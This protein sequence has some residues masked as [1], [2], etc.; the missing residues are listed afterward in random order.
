MRYMKLIMVGVGLLLGTT[1][2]FSQINIDALA[3]Y[4]TPYSAVYPGYINVA[5]G[6]PSGITVGNQNDEIIS[7]TEIKFCPGFGCTSIA[8]NGYFKAI[9]GAPTL[10][11]VALE[12]GNTNAVGLYEKIEFGL[13]MPGFDA[14]IE[15]F[16]NACASQNTPCE[17][18]PGTTGYTNAFNAGTLLNPYDPEHISVEAY[19]FSPTTSQMNNAKKRFGFFYRTVNRVEQNG[20]YVDWSYEYPNAQYTSSVDLYEWRVRFAPDEIGEWKVVIRY[21]IGGVLQ[22]QFYWGSFTVV[23]SDNKGFVKVNPINNGYLQFQNGE[24]F[25]P[26]GDNYCWP[27]TNGTCEPEGCMSAN[28]VSEWDSR[29]LPTSFMEET[30]VLDRLSNYGNEVEGG[31][32]SRVWQSAGGFDFEWERLGNYNTRQI[33]MFEFDE[34]LKLAK[35][36]G[37]YLDVSSILSMIDNGDTHEKYSSAWLFNP[38]HDAPYDHGDPL[39]NIGAKYRG[40]EDLDQPMEFFTNPTAIKFYKNK[41]RYLFSRWGYA[42]NFAI[43]EFT[44]EVDGIQGADHT[45]YW[46]LY[47]GLI[48]TWCN[49][50]ASYIKNEL[51]AKQLITSSFGEGYCMGYRNSNHTVLWDMGNIDLVTS[52]DY[53]RSLDLLTYKNASTAHAIENSNKPCMIQ[54]ASV[55]GLNQIDPCSDRAWH[56]IL[57]SSL[58]SGAYGAAMN[59]DWRKYRIDNWYNAFNGEFANEYGAARLFMNYVD[60]VTPNYTPVIPCPISLPCHVPGQDDRLENFYMVRNDRKKLYGWFYN[61]SY[62]HYADL[63]GCNYISNPA[64]DCYYEQPFATMTDVATSPYPNASTDTDYPDEGLGLVNSANQLNYFGIFG[65]PSWNYV[66]ENNYSLDLTPISLPSLPIKLTGL[67]D[68]TDYIIEYYYTQGALAGTFYPQILFTTEYD[69]SAI[70]PT[71]PTGGTWPNLTSDWAYLVHLR[72]EPRS[73]T[74]S[75]PNNESRDNDLLVTPNPNTGSFTVSIASTQGGNTSIHLFNAHGQEIFTTIVTLN[76]GTTQLYLDNLNLQSGMY[77]VKVD[78]LEKIEKVI[79]SK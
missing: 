63:G 4:N 15:N 11:V 65:I 1:P 43:Y 49:N 51:G 32:F 16:F 41:L 56:N 55:W 39:D 10:D 44:N 78:G 58:V 70:V 45:N 77:F 40:I 74:I 5:C 73:M 28:C 29:I 8:G 9:I 13:N 7:G 38:Y 71:P 26:V 68:H 66:D 35:E 57:W 53:T 47:D 67:I 52:H 36:R 31:N 72:G 19:F 18:K 21:S 20:E 54:E 25:F 23:P 30:K 48:S 12:P 59:W 14:R 76:E 17:Y 69:G 64:T 42:T 62:H 22:D 6:A 24:Q 33:E 61:R 75:T 37:V 27:M 2:L 60:L 79:I 34:Y 3:L 46:N 50:M